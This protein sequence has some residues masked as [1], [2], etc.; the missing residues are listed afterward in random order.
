MNE[1][2]H[3]N[4]ELLSADARGRK[5]IPVAVFAVIM[6]HV[7]LFVVLLIAAGCRSSARVK[8]NVSPTPERAEQQAIAN[9]DVPQIAANESQIPATNNEPVMATEPVVEPESP[10]RAVSSEN[11]A[12]TRQPSASRSIAKPSTSRSQKFYVVKA[13][14][15]LEKI[16]KLHG[17]TIQAVRTA[18]RIKSDLIH[19][20]QKLQLTPGGSGAAPLQ[21]RSD[22]TKRANEA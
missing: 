13:G 8:R 19:P 2:T 11:I 12:Q 5:Q 6:I 21:V 9:P 4:S 22:K 17:T 16:A 20:G 10:Q 18:N 7:V 14:D 1:T 3:L 15:T